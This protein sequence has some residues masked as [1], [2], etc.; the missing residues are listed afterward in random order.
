MAR[1]C[2][3]C[4]KAIS[5]GACPRCKARPR[6]PRAPRTREQEASRSA[7]HPERSRYSSKAYR[8][9][10]QAALSRTQGRCASCGARI[11]TWRS[12]RWVMLPGRG[13][14]HHSTPMRSGGSDSAANLVP[15]CSRCHN[16]LDAELRRSDSVTR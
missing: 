11:A 8:E 16:R 1:L 13:G 2:P 6:T 12:G 3:T 4:G 9:A 7:S 5:S 14:C 15:L 10:R